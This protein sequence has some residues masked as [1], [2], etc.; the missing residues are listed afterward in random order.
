[1]NTGSQECYIDGKKY[2]IDE[3]IKNEKLVV[4]CKKGKK[5]YL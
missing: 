4:K 1:M 2:S 5:N 3:F